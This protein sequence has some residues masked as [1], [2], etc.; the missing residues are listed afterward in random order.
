MPLYMFTDESLNIVGH[1][2]AKS[3]DAAKEQR[4]KK[5]PGA[6]IWYMIPEEIDLQD[7]DKIVTTDDQRGNIGDVAQ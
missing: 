1:C 5:H 4:D 3:L 7:G 6:S 2:A